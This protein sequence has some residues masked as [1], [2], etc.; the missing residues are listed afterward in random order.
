M[1]KLLKNYAFKIPVE[2]KELVDKLPDHE[3]AELN[4]R[5]RIEIA[6]KIHETTFNPEDYLGK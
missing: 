4:H 5:L 1:K 3:K 2:M 6:R